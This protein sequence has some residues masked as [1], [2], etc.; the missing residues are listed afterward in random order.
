[1][2]K[3]EGKIGS[4]L[5]V[6][7]KK[8]IK[9]NIGFIKKNLL[10]ETK[11]M[12]MIKANA[13]GHGAKNIA[14]FIEE[15]KL[16]DYL[17]IADV[18]RGIELRKAGISLPIM[19]SNPLCSQLQNCKDFSL[20]PVIHN[21]KLLDKLE[22]ISNS[23]NWT[24]PLS[25]H[26]K[27]NTGMN[28]FGFQAS[29]VLPLFEFIIANEGIKLIG[30]MSHLSCSDQQDEDEFT[31]NQFADFSSIEQQFEGVLEDK[32]MFHL[33]NTNGSIRFPKHQFDMIRSGI[34]IYGLSD[35]KEVQ[36]QLLPV[37][38]LTCTLNAL[39]FVKKGGSVSYNRSGKPNRDTWVGVVS[40]GYGDGFP[41]QLG[42]G[43]WEFELEG[44]LYPTIGNICM[45]FTLI[46]LGPELKNLK[47]EDQ[48]IVFG[49]LKSIYDFADAQNTICYEVLSQ[50]KESVPR[51][52]V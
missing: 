12:V 52:L 4:N 37:A 6:I 8:K 32:I 31:N 45:D 23:E 51:Q 16:A 50:I 27:F 24:K 19:V 5:L 47:E 13:Y 44:E 42:N 18:N 48:F 10:P 36:D 26:L 17:G 46:E 35:F 7:D 9:S 33:L 49:G 11:V 38:K 25:I 14:Q 29:D 3:L 28:R 20:D 43:N 39:Q 15:N 22:E 2:A 41:R 30:A 40:I 21:W 1:M 34:G